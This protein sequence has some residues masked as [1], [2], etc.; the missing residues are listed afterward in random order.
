MKMHASITVDRVVEAVQR[1]I[2][3][4]DNPGLCV[5][6]GKDAD[7]CEPDA[8]KYP[9]EHCGKRGVYGADELLLF[10]LP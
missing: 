4:L 6:C 1:R 5:L 7:G 2:S 9:C 10:L 8:R 3:S